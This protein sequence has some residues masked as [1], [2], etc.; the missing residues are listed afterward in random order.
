MCNTNVYSLWYVY[1]TMGLYIYIYILFFLW[2]YNRMM[3]LHVL[4]LMLIH[5]LAINKWLSPKRHTQNIMGHTYTWRLPRMLSETRCG[6]VCF[7]GKT[8]RSSGEASFLLIF[9]FQGYTSIFRHT[10]IHSKY[11]GIYGCV[12]KLGKSLICGQWIEKIMK[13][14]WNWG[15]HFQINP[16]T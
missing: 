10:D 9:H 8:P 16:H 5:N 13:A 15:F 4:G 12:W 6:S 3:Q 2:K 1:G 11:H 7:F 14:H